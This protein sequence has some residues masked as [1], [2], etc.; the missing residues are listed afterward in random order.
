M[1]TGNFKGNLP[2]GSSLFNFSLPIKSRFDLVWLIGFSLVL[3]DFYFLLC[4]M[5]SS[6]V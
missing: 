2:R 1:F 3:F 4:N 6:V 5:D